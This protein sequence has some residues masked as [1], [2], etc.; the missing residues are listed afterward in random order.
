M[1]EAASL[2][3]KGFTCDTTGKPKYRM[4]ITLALLEGLKKD[5]EGVACLEMD[6][7]CK[8]ESGRQLERQIGQNEYG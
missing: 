3:Q 2:H 8:K 5:F 7:L 1:L 6:R 4:A